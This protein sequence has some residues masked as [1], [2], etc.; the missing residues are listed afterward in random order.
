M[1]WV[2]INTEIIFIFGWTIPSIYQH[3]QFLFIKK[4]LFNLN[5]NNYS[6]NIRN[7]L[8]N[9]GG[10]GWGF[11]YCVG[12]WAA[13][14]S[15]RLRTID[16]SS[17]YLMCSQLCSASVHVVL[18]LEDVHHL[19]GVEL[20]HALHFWVL[21]ALWGFLGCFFDLFHLHLLT[22]LALPNSP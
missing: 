13:L 14:E 4:I 22:S 3:S 20:K 17:L 21:A 9:M 1:T 5:H 12:Q 15:K 16:L 19:V 18:R 11:K 8:V 6:R 2:W 7:F 10:W